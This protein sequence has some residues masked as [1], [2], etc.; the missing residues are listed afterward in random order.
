MEVRVWR[1]SP[2]AVTSISAT[3]LL[4]P[5]S[6]LLRRGGPACSC[7]ETAFRL[8][9]MSAAASPAGALPWVNDPEVLGITLES[10]LVLDSP[11]PS[12]ISLEATEV[13]RSAMK[14]SEKCR[15]L[16]GNGL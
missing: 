9:E 5:A 16:S 4:P 3:V 12:S 11:W 13:L 6:G 14:F 8:V 10:P 7:R 1:A 15:I 2:P